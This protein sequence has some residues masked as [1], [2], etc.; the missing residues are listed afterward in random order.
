MII[1][2]EQVYLNYAILIYHLK[3]ITECNLHIKKFLKKINKIFSMVCIKS[4]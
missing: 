4:I 3:K 2:Y 1:H